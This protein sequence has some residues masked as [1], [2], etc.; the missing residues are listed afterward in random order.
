MAALPRPARKDGA[1]KER[2]SLGASPDARASTQIVSFLILHRF[3]DGQKIA[4]LF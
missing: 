4:A 3:A 1:K 2:A